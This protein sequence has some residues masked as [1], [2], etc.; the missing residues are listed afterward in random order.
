MKAIT[1]ET[2]SENN[3]LYRRILDKG[4]VCHN[5]F[6]LRRDPEGY[7]DRR[8]TTIEYAHSE[9]GVSQR[10]GTWCECG[11]D[12]AY[13]RSWPNQLTPNRQKELFTQLAETLSRMHYNVQKPVVFHHLV[14]YLDTSRSEGEFDDWLHSHLHDIVED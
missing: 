5:C 6:R 2:P 4:R 7:R 8:N 11:P 3:G 10:R 12:T 9:G 13:Y 1:K 14:R